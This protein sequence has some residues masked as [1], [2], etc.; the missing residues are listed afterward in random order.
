M[1]TDKPTFEVIENKGQAMPK[2]AARAAQAPRAHRKAST[3]AA[4]LELTAVA[5]HTVVLNHIHPRWV[6][7]VVAGRMLLGVDVTAD[8][9]AI[10]RKGA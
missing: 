8:D 10:I 7:D 4:Y 1:N 6:R 9:I 5:Q 3:R 2:G